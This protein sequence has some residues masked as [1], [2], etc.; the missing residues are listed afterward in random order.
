MAGEADFRIAGARIF[1]AARRRPRASAFAVSGDRLVAV[2]TEAQISRWAGRRTRRIDASG[3]Y[4]S[5]EESPEGALE[6]GKL[7][8][9][10][11]LDG[12]PFQ[13]PE[14]IRDCHVRST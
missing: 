6:A 10:V 11:V 2:G 4:A 5:F 8:D 7:A 14:R 9:F 3:A 13:R 1:T 12:D